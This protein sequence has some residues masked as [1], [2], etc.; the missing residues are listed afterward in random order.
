VQEVVAE[1]MM[2][3]PGSQDEQTIMRRLRQEAEILKNELAFE[4]CATRGV[5]RFTVHSARRAHAV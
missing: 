2:P 1:G 3:P 5:F 4:R